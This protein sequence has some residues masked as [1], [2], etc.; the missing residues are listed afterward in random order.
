MKNIFKLRSQ[1]C[2]GGYSVTMIQEMPE[3]ELFCNFQKK[4]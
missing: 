1:L 4:F 3:K 2:K